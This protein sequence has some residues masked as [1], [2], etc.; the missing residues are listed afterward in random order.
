MPTYKAG[1][2]LTFPFTSA[3]REERRS[4]S[5]SSSPVMDEPLAITVK[6]IDNG[7]F[8]RRLIDQVRTGDVL[9][10][11]GI[12]GLFTLPDPLPHGTSLLLFAAG[13]GITPL[14]SILKTALRHPA[15]PS[16]VL[17]YSNHS[18]P[19]TVFY[20]ELVQ[21]QEQ[22][23]ERLRI[24]WLFSDSKYLQRARL[25][26]PVM[27]QLM[28]QYLTDVSKT[29]CYI[30][31]PTDYRW[32]VQLLLEEAGLASEQIRQEI[33]MTDRHAILQVPPDQE[34]HQVSIH[35]GGRVVRLEVRYPE[36]ILSAAKK[37]GIR[38]PYS[39]EAGRCSSC[40]VRCT[41]GA[42]WMGYNEVLTDKDLANGLV[43]TCTG[44]PVKGD[45]SLLFEGA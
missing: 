21:L 31:G 7:A 16:I 6:R 41:S 1:Q 26:R 2:F 20:E 19:A 14:Y 40:A 43:L 23:P 13:I 24:E 18:R 33:F 15:A 4:Y 17:V 37:A 25:T 42:V 3:G 27:D 28:Q 8:S 12:S 39:C 45:I 10:T 11:A 32:L 44:Y 29:Y 30:C 22:Y 35:I 5:F 36:T 34:P 38:L 9:A